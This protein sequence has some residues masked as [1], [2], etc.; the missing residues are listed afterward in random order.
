MLKIHDST[1][2]NNLFCFFLHLNLIKSKR[3]IS[4]IFK[5]LC[6]LFFFQRLILKKINNISIFSHFS[7]FSKNK[8]YPNFNMNYFF[9]FFDKNFAYWS[10]NFLTKERFDPSSV[11]NN[12]PIIDY[13]DYLY[14]FLWYYHYCVTVLF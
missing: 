13:K 3:N 2:N 7:Y 4:L 1:V 11:I 6:S 5:G 12:Y 9:L 14:V 8:G 10:N